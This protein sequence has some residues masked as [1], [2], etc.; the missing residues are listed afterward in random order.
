MFRTACEWKQRR[1][2]ADR[3]GRLFPRA[4]AHGAL[5]GELHT[6]FT[7]DGTGG[8]LTVRGDDDVYVFINKKLVVDLGGTHVAKSLEI[9]LD[10]L[11]LTIGQTYPLDLFYA[12]R[13]G[14]TGDLAITTTL[15]LK[16]ASG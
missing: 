1:P 9:A 12:E 13:L 5:T 6:V 11:G 15:A 4:G 2:H 3:F 16:P 7:L 8:S 10:G 14:A